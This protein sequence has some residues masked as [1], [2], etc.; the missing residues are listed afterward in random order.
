[1]TS[2]TVISYPIPPYQNLP[3]EP[4]WYQPRGFFISDITLGITTIVTTAL[5]MDYVVGQEIRLIIPGNFGTYQLNGKTGFVINII[6][7]NQVEI[8]IN[9]INCD[10]FILASPPTFLT[11]AFTAAQ[12]LAIGDINSGQTNT[13]GD[14]QNLTYIPGSFIN[15]SPE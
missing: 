7:S 12:I 14:M 6:S 4:Q 15:I 13:N 5:D 11:Q 8:N 10:A 2:S 3:I 9:S 1:M